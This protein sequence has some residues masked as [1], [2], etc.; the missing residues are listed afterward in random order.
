[1]EDRGE[2]IK[3]NIQ[4]WMLSCRFLF[5]LFLETSFG[6]CIEEVDIYVEKLQKLKLSI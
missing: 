3:G 1:M 5:D 6:E 4:I 2:K